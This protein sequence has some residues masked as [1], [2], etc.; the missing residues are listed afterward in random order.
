[1][2]RLLTSRQSLSEALRT[3]GVVPVLGPEA[4]L[5]EMAGTDGGRLTVP[6][7]QVVADEL[8]RT[9]DTT[10]PQQPTFRTGSP[11]LLHR[12]VAQVLADGTDIS[13]ERLRRS[14]SAI[15]KSVSSRALSS[16]L[17]ARLAALRAFDLFICLTPDDF[18]VE[19]LR[20]ALGADNVEV[21]AYAPNADS[22]Q[23]VDVS[24]A[25][26]GVARVFFPLGRSA[27][28]T[29]LAIH[30]EDALEFIYKFQE[31]GVRRAPNLLTELRSRDLLLLGCN[32][33]D[34]LGRGF[35]RLANES[36]LSSQDKK[37]EFFAADAQDPALNSFLSRFDPNA[38]IF[39]WSPQEFITE[40]ETMVTPAAQP[41]GAVSPVPTAV[42]RA[43]NGAGA[44]SGPTVFVSYASENVEAARRLA[45][46]LAAL[47][48][49]DVW[50]DKRKLIAGDDW[51]DNIDEAI[52]HCDF[53]MPVLS[54]QA[55]Q[56][57]EGVF[58]EEW[59]KAVMRA[60][61]VNDAFLLPVGIDVTQPDR[62]AYD[63]IFNGFT[64]E[65]R[66]LHLIH[67]PQGTLSDDDTVQLRVRC[68]RFRGVGGG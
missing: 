48:F 29:R 38:S 23:P 16:L 10:L 20:Q 47:G 6:F 61:R 37:M 33:P 60:M 53:F 4:V 5:V 67:A 59:R 13:A 27:A 18:L 36:R 54:R 11:W 26:A 40:L 17:L 45:Q 50:L 31:E 32:L 63:R 25:R 12:A 46:S 51:S 52:E 14:V 34:W 55:D 41:A 35:L 9:Y 30:E 66:R 65:F 24:P 49:A 15:V 22:S 44:L 19:A 28:G 8:L 21:G 2:D 58:W 39:P 64:N 57:R 62:T 56:R 68:E 43:A 7:Y 1:M 42:R 3:N